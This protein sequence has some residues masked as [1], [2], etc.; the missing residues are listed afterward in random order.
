MRREN[1]KRNNGKTR[2]IPSIPA[3]QYPE[4]SMEPKN[5]NKCQLRSGNL[6]RKQKK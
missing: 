3:F 4:S 2:D 1:M 5:K 6:R